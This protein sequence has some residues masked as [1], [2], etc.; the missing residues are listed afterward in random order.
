[1][2]F[3]YAN[4][5]SALDIKLNEDQVRDLE[6]PFTEDEVRMAV[7]Q[8]TGHKAPRPDGFV[9]G[10]Y[11]N[12][13][14]LVGDDVTKMVLAFLHS[15]TMLREINRT[16]INLIP[17]VPNVVSVNDFRPISLFNV[18]YKI[19]AS[20]MVNRLRPV[21]KSLISIFQHAFV[22][23]HSITDNVFLAHEVLEY[24]RHHNR[25]KGSYF[26]LKFDMNKAY[27]RVKWSA[28]SSVL[29]QLG[30]SPRWVNVIVQCISIVSFSILINGCP[31]KV[32]HPK[33]GLRQGNPLSPY[34][35][36][37]VSPVLSANLSL[38]GNSNV[39]KGVVVSSHSP[40]IAHLL[41][42]DNS[43]F[44]LKFDL[45]DIQRLKDLIDDCCN[46]AG[47]RINSN[48]SEIFTSPNMLME[49]RRV[50]Q[51]TFVIRI[52]N[53][54]GIYLGSNLDFTKRKGELFRRIAD[55]FKNR[56]ANWHTPCLSIA[57]H[58]VLVQHCLSSIPIYLFSIFRA[59]G[60]FVREVKS[61]MI[62]FLWGKGDG[63]GVCWKRWVE[64]CKPMRLGG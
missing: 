20:V 57:G 24:I 21:L 14:S 29:C 59:P 8:M 11:Q 3:K 63:E 17:K 18:L 37:L 61:I 32:F 56:L 4:I 45:G 64:F 15:G 62:R 49:D 42:A 25:G 1:M 58:L 13:W 26:A 47:Q 53:K 44:F 5:L 7:F 9:A 40:L 34:L 41:F 48:K 12:N 16:Y 50:L 19:I 31:S 43:F 30:F 36:I 33:C 60:Y 6:A 23:D 54:L 2:V 35:F 46:F 22:P 52:V 27:D 39:C 51:E 28:V 55:R 10:F 38:F